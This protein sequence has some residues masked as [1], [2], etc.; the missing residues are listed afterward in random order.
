MLHP[1]TVLQPEYTHLLSVMKVERPIPI[2][3]GLHVIE[4]R[5]I[6]NYKTLSENTKVPAIFLAALDLREGDCNPRTG[7]GQGDPWEH[8]STHV[9][10]GKGPFKDWLSANIYYVNYDHLNDTTA[11]WSYPYVCWKG[12]GWNGFGPRGHGR[13]T[14]YLWSCTNV[15]D[16]GPQ[17][18]HDGGQGGKYVADGQWDPNAEDKQPGIIPVIFELA[19]V[20]PDLA[21]GAVPVITD[22][23]PLVPPII[24]PPGLSGPHENTQALQDALNKLLDLDPPL[25]A[26]GNYGRMTRNAVRSFQRAHGLPVDGIAGPMT[27]TAVEK[28]LAGLGATLLA[29][30]HH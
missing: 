17:G 19:R 28:S 22:A 7:I 2:E 18:I 23:P 27:N 6:D 26:D 24:T 11:P 1:F 15:Y 29:Q 3:E 13:H 4:R 10:R 14:G 5:G 8:V 20:Y 12:E 16:P 21:L 25:M 30:L 9:P